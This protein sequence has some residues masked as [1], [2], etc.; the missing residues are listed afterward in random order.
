MGPRAPSCHPS[1]ARHPAC[2]QRS[3][4]ARPPALPCRASR[5]PC[6]NATHL[7][8]HLLRAGRP[9]GRRL[10]A[11]L[12]VQAPIAADG[13][14][15]LGSQVR[16]VVVLLDSRGR[17]Q[18]RGVKGAAAAAAAAAGQRLQDVRSCLEASARWQGQPLHSW[19]PLEGG[20]CRKVQGQDAMGQHA[21]RRRQQQQQLQAVR[22]RR[23][24]VHRVP[25]AR[26]PHHF[27][28][29]ALFL[30]SLL[31]RRLLGRGG[32]RLLLAPRRRRACRRESSLRVPAAC[33]PASNVAHMAAASCTYAACTCIACIARMLRPPSVHAPHTFRVGRVAQAP[34]GTQAGARGGF[35]RCIA[36]AAAAVLVTV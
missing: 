8:S 24:R 16:H 31:G 29:L 1:L 9:A 15:T 34:A 3:P 21:W 28:L 2:R 5:R 10:V 18:G 19:R 36:A 35:D 11:S 12:S 26:L 7:Q 6:L 17:Q 23:A 20:R 32:R 13:F 30:G 33:L 14:F 4:R 22:R 25:P 27:R